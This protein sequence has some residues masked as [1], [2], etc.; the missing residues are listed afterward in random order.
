MSNNIPLVTIGIPVYN[1]EKYLRE[2]LDSVVKQDYQ[3][4]EIIIA[5]NSST[6]STQSIC[7]EYTELY[8]QIIYHRQ[9]ENIGAVANFNY[10]VKI[11][12]GSLFCWLANDDFLAPT[13]ISSCVS[14][15]DLHPQAIACC[16][17]I[18]FINEDGG[19]RASWTNCYSNID[20]LGKDIIERTREVTSKVG[21]YAVYSVFRTEVLRQSSLC[22]PKYACDVLLLIELLLLGEIVKVPEHLFYYRVASIDKTPEDYIRI[23]NINP[24]AATEIRKGSF[25]YLAKQVLNTVYASQASVQDKHRIQVDFMQ[26]LAH[27]NHDWLG[28]IAQ[29]QGW[30]NRDLTA[31]NIQELLTATIISDEVKSAIAQHPPLSPTKT[32]VFFPHNPYPV[33]TGAHRRCLEM[34]AGLRDL[35]CEVLLFSSTIYSDQPWTQQS[36]DFLKVKYGIDTFI[37]QPTADDNHYLEACRNRP[38]SDRINWEYFNTPGL[39]GSFKQIFRQFQPTL[40]VVSYSLWGRLVSGKEFDA[41][42]KVIDTIDLIS[43]TLQ[44]FAAA[45][46]YFSQPAIDPATV[47]IEVTNEDFFRKLDLRP[48]QEEYDICDLYDYTIGISQKEN[49]L[50]IEHTHQTEN[51]YIPMSVEIPQ[52]INAYSDLPLFV[53]SGNC[54]NLQGATYFINKILPLIVESIPDF[55]LRVVGTGSTR[56]TPNPVLDIGGF[57]EDLSPLYTQGGFAICPLIG[58]T[59]QQ[60]KIVEAMAHGLPVVGLI[61][62]AETSPIEHGIN[63]FIAHN[64]E[65]FARYTILLWQDRNLCKQM[66]EAARTTMTARCSSSSVATELREIVS[67]ANR[68]EWQNPQPQIA[69]DGVFFQLYSTGIARVWRS[70]LEEWA[71]GTFAEHLIVLDRVGTAPRI[72]GISY[73]QIPAYDYGNTDADRQMLQQ[74]CDELGVDLFI[75]TYYT[76]P[77]ETPSVFMGYDMIPEMLGADLTHPM[78]Q[79]KRRAIEHAS[80]Y[81]TISKH[82]A[83]D[84]IEIYPDIDPQTVTVAHCG[85]Q[86]TFKL[87]N[88]TN[89]VEFRDKYGINKPYFIISASGGYK[90]TELFLQAFAQLPTKSGFEIIVTGGQILSDEFRQYILGIHVHY[91]R[92]DDFELSLAYAGATALVYPSKYEGF[93]LPIVEAM[94]SACPVITCPNASIPE[95]AG[96]AAIYIFDD[97]VD[98]MAE[99]LCEVQKPQVRAALIAAGLEQ[100]KQFSWFKMGEIVKAVLIEQTLSHLR[101]SEQ[102]LIIF[103]DWSQD[104]AELGDEI[105]SICYELSQSSEFVDGASGNRVTLLVDTTNLDSFESVNA[106]MSSIVMNLM[107]SEDV[108]ITEH[109]EIALTGNLSPIQWQVLVTKLQGRIKLEREDMNAISQVIGNTND[110]SRANL[111]S[112]IQL[113]KLPILALV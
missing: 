30:N 22:Q 48:E 8:T 90:N 53:I 108:D 37:Y 65:E 52:I 69:I 10:L 56:L 60:V 7:Q 44:M 112:E 89:L 55:Q 25:T 88:V 27:I 47:A 81:L 29:E 93:G 42:V 96:D 41:V 3:N 28:R 100:V 68:V 105:M 82:T 43:L 91:L 46:P 32:L 24:E 58:G 97:D 23:F 14:K 1:G 64:A 61:N 51:L 85:V 19:L 80:A 111:L 16:S 78:W 57:I 31:T 109:L 106:L 50:L 45:T 5:D 26:T 86:S 2:A 107:M 33:K 103:P 21:W 110:P 49:S 71:G 9:S 67:I 17:E 74:V 98:G 13:Y 6:D 72:P 73:Y 79:E 35:G 38:Q 11:A 15:L 4:L 75:S 12:N 70:L 34:L 101:L 62:V 99:A 20:G 77:L 94:A 84:L 87:A 104:E 39:M 36:I 83:Q 59:G 76:T 18:N 40:V 113:T 95:V 92:L 63:G 54:F 66:G 102:N